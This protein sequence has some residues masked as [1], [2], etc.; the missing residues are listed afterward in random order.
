MQALWKMEEIEWT[1]FGFDARGFVLTELWVLEGGG[2]N[3]Y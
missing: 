3:Q 2:V 1:L